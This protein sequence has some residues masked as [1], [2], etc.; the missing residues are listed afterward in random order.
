MKNNRYNIDDTMNVGEILEQAQ[1]SHP[2][3]SAQIYRTKPQY[4]RQQ[5]AT[6]QY[7]RTQ[8]TQQYCNT[9][10]SYY[11]GPKPIEELVDISNGYVNYDTDSLKKRKKNRKRKAVVSAILVTL[12]VFCAGFCAFTFLGEF[13]YAKNVYVND[14][15]IGGMNKEEAR[16]VLNK[17]EDKLANSINISISAGDNTTTITKEDIDCTF[18]TDRILQQAEIYSK[19]VFFPKDEKRYTISADVDNESIKAVSEKV[20][21]D[22]KQEPADAKVTQFDSSKKGADRFTFEDEKVGTEINIDNLENQL[23]EFIS[24]GKLSGDI[25]AQTTATNP[26]YTKEHLVNN[27]KE[28]SSYSTTATGSENSRSN[29]NLAA[30]MCNNSIIDPDEVW[31]FNTCTGDSSL[32]SNGYAPAPVYVNG[33][34]DTGIGGGICQTSSTIYNAGLYCGLNVQERLPHA[35]PSKYVPIGLDAT[36]DYGNIDLK[37]QNTFDYQLFMECYMEGDTVV[38]KFYGLENPDFD[39]VEVT[40]KIT[41]SST[42][43]ASR[44]FYKNG[45]RVTGASLPDEELPSSSYNS[46]SISESYDTSNDTHLEEEDTPETTEEQEVEP[47]Y[48]S[49]SEE[50]ATPEFEP[51]INPDPEPDPPLDIYT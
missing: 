1:C 4:T 18:D 6:P 28:L 16:K 43:T 29:M 8:S 22:L 40:S 27:I 26:Q 7:V 14:V 3:S 13:K 36:I 50:E 37:L 41:S 38:C 23:D 17:E 32:E 21:S 42:A 25:T 51:E 15:C 5:Y 11:R 10:N 12:F 2:P 9:A 19:S 24:S 31:S 44:T 20:A 48:E 35:E 39:E 46:N 49:E 47:E 30:T 34:L 33:E 45:K